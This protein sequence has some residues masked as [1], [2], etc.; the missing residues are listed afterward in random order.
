MANLIKKHKGDITFACYSERGII[1]HLMFRALPCKLDEFLRLLRFPEGVQHPFLEAKSEDLR[2]V[3]LFSEMDLGDFGN[4][5]GAIFVNYKGD[6]FFVFLEGKSN[7]TYEV[8][9]KEKKRVKRTKG[10]DLNAIIERL[11]PAPPGD[12]EPQEGA[13]PPPPEGKRLKSEYSSTIRG[14][15]ELKYRMIRLYKHYG[16]EALKPLTANV[17]EEL[18]EEVGNDP[19]EI[20]SPEE[21]REE[22]CLR[23]IQA[24]KEFYQGTGKDKD[25]FYVRPGRS[26]P[27]KLKSWRHLW[28]KDGVK[29]VFDYLKRTQENHILF[30]AFTT[31]QTNPFDTVS[32]ELRPRF[33][34]AI[35][36]D[37][38]A[39]FPWI[40]SEVIEKQWDNV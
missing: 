1:A 18:L 9:C 23:E 25:E 16:K 15:L 13:E 30:L 5:D 4:P 10:N 20:P 11:N 24:A 7:E 32:A 22:E 37:W 39:R 31:D 33:F 21:A 40:S 3:T 29:E 27:S 8:S 12:A 28:I 2:E 26:D 35:W 36:D 17:I 19:G 6:N 34:D 14:Q 38:K